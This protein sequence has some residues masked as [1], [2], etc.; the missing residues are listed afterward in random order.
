[1]TVRDLIREAVGSLASHRL[2]AM[3][4]A[5]G[6]VA[7]VGTVVAALAIASGAQRQAAADIGALG[8][9]NIVIRA[10][11]PDD[12][13]KEH[14]AP[15]LRVDDGPA[16]SREFPGSTIAELRTLHDTASVADAHIPVTVA[17]VAREWRRTMGFSV[18][19]G[20]WFGERDANARVAVAGAG[21]ARTLFHGSDA[22]G[23][24]VLA[25]GE[26]RTIVGVLASGG[27]RSGAGAIH[28]LDSDGALFVPLATLDLSLGAGDSG[29][30]VDEIVVR[31]PTGDDVVRGA[32]AVEAIL[33]ARHAGEPGAF[34]IVVPREL[35]RVRLRSQRMAQM[36]LMAI[37]G[38][39]LFIGGIGILNIM[40]ASVTERTAE[41]G[42]RR[43]V[44]A[45]RWSVLVQFAAEAALLGG[46]GGLA[47]V[48]IGALGA[49]SVA[50]IAGWPIALSG[51]A[52]MGALGMAFVVGLGAGIYP[53]HLAASVSPI[54][55]LRG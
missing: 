12:T 31:L 30:A 22:I 8:I 55:A 18:A 13:R 53:A 16:L 2:R 14:P 11:A 29:D 39:A 20:R 52:V 34:E 47:G 24:T 38:L 5:L 54:D 17:G 28:T 25:A 32:A 44:G 4:A 1:M 41:I 45:P 23:R 3:L 21:L 10:I 6:S 7:G 43:A 33:R 27:A 26:W 9:D 42:V 19:A 40:V 35:L 48:P 37:G 49:V 46:A 36:L 50:W 15:V 51:A